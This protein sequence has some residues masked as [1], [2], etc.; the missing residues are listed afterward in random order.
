MLELIKPQVC[1]AHFMNAKTMRIDWFRV[2]IDRSFI[3]ESRTFE[4]EL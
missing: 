3:D 2:N 4:Q 1:V